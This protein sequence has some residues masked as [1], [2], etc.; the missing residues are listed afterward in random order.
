MK[1]KKILTII[2][3]C[4]VMMPLISGCKGETAAASEN[5]EDYS[6]LTNLKSGMFY[7]R[8][9]DNSCEPLVMGDPNFSDITTYADPERVVWFKDDAKSVPTLYPGDSLILY[10]KEEF[11]ESFTFER[12]N[13]LGYT[14]G[15][16]SLTQ[17]ESG[18]YKVST[19]KDKKCTYP[20]NSTDEI[21]R[22]DNENVTI[23]E[24]A[25]IPLRAPNIGDYING[26]GDINENAYQDASQVSPA[27]TIKG[28]KKDFSYDVKVFDGTT[29]H[30]YTWTADTWALSS[31]E[32][33]TTHRFDYESEVVINIYIPE[34]YHSGYYTVNSIGMF[35]YVTED[36]FDENTDF[37]IPNLI[38]D[39]EDSTA[40]T[41]IGESQVVGEYSLKEGSTS[42]DDMATAVFKVETKDP[43]IATIS[44]PEN[45]EAKPKITANVVS[46]SG[47]RYR[48]EEEGG[49]YS[50]YLIPEETGSFTVEIYG[51]DG[52]KAVVNI[53]D[54]EGE[55]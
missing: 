3:A 41:N 8:H 19:D 38:E 4:T 45:K 33:E 49:S 43:V 24:I 47:K 54:A 30:D 2:L 55:H 1:I 42:R 35:R 16:R 20:G 36:S 7:V 23:D 32:A 17:T 46:P 6:C 44:F 15:V 48:M 22:F 25:G 37:N 40:Y 52:Q 12:F 14:F 34:S 21:L 5:K 26:D 53:D 28:L 10:S 18:R 29:E 11:E 13:D 50:L 31:M 27:G 39:E 9:K 51:L